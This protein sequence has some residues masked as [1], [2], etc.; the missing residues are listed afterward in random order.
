MPVWLRT[1]LRLTPIVAGVSALS[2]VGLLVVRQFVTPEDLSRSTD[3]VGNYLQTVGGIYAVLLAFVV[4]IVWG[5][6]N[7][8]RG[9]VER[10][11]TALVDLHRTASGL[12]SATRIEIQ[13]ELREY[14]DAVLAEEWR[15]MGRGDE[16]TLERVGAKLDHVWLAIH[17]CKPASECQHTVYSEVLSRF[18][19]L[20]DMRT[21]RLTASRLRIP[22]A[23]RILLVAGAF[24][25]IASTYLLAV[26]KL[27]IHIV[28]TSALA[29][30]IA[31]ILYLIV[32]LDDAFAGDL[33]VPQAAF[34][35]ARRT[36]ER[37]THLVDVEAA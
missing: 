23:M 25:C 30:A 9:F 22:L 20:T 21:S 32:D 15:A 14:V 28:I 13:R 34:V 12:P 26:E 27:W 37:S 8:A 36:C 6:F 29:G 19:D 18:N 2:V 17:R 24:I 31:H 5:Q 1:T 10:E 11:A 4:F 35:R 3:A 16:A 33:Q 7:D